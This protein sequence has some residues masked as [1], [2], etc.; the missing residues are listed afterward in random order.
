MEMCGYG[1]KMGGRR[2]VPQINNNVWSFRDVKKQE[3]PEC[4][5]KS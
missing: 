2:R 4:F 3:D 1:N 5:C